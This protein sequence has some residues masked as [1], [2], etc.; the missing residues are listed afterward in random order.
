MHDRQLRRQIGRHPDVDDQHLGAHLARQD[1]DRRAAAREVVHHLRRHRRGIGGHAFGGDAVV[2][3]HHNHQTLL[4]SRPRVAGNAANL[5]REAFET[6]EAAAW[7]GQAV[8][9]LAHCSRYGQVE[10]I[11]A[12][13]EC[14][15]APPGASWVQGALELFGALDIPVRQRRK[16]RCL[17]DQHAVVAKRR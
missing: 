7:L 2:G 8:E 9:A 13:A 6:A 11:D 3:N 5:D 14:S 4:Q 17:H 15:R 12:P 10:L 16:Q 1:V